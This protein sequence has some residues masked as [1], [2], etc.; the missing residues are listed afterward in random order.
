MFESRKGNRMNK[1]NPPL[2]CGQAAK[3]VEQSI[4]LQYWYCEKCKNE[5]TEQPV[6]NYGGAQLL[7]SSYLQAVHAGAAR[8]P[9]NNDLNQCYM[10]FGGIIVLLN[11][12]YTDRTVTVKDVHNNLIF[13]MDEAHWL[14]YVKL[15][16]STRMSLGQTQ[17]P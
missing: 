10:Y 2:C 3:W 17:V 7:M 4:N 15:L 9:N 14:Q 1:T 8:F 6:N 11:V 13:F 5:V 12:D 16:P